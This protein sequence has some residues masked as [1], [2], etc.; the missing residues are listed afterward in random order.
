MNE[1]QIQVPPLSE[2]RPEVAAFARLMEHKLR[3]HDSDWGDGWKTW[4]PREALQ[5]LLAEAEEISKEINPPPCG[6]RSAGHELCGGNAYW[7]PD[8]LKTGF[9]A[10]DAANFAMMIAG[11]C[12]ALDALK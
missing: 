3:K 2:V 5:R 9:E 12:G 6:C 11:M 8:P 1:F 7:R 4:D 10:A